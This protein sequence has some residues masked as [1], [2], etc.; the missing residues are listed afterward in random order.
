MDLATH[1]RGIQ[2][3]LA[4]AA[5]LGG[6][7]LAEAGRRLAKLL[8]GTLTPR[9]GAVTLDGDA[10]AGLSRRRIAQRIAAFETDVRYHNRSPSA[11]APYGYESTLLGLAQWADALVVAC[12]ADATN[13]G[14]INAEVLSALGAGGHIVNISRGSVIDE[15]ALV[16]ALQTGVIAGAGLDAYGT[17]PLPAGHPFRTLPNV[18]PSPHIGYVSENVYRL[19]FADIVGDVTAFLDGSPVRVITP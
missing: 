17:E 8:G 5:A 3:E 9:A 10:L 4:A 1:V 16:S 7:E 18:L 12:R 11:G 14:M 6:D 13:R 19:F 2:T 15:P